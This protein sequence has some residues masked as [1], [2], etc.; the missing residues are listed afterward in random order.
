MDKASTVGSSSKLRELRG[1]LQQLDSRLT[2]LEEAPVVKV[3]LARD[4]TLKSVDYLEEALVTLRQATASRFALGDT[5]AESLKVDHAAL[6]KQL[7]VLRTIARQSRDSTDRDSTA[8]NARV[9]DDVAEH[10]R[11]HYASPDSPAKRRR[12]SSSRERTLTA[13]H[14][15]AWAAS[16][17]LQSEPLPEGKRFACVLQALID[18]PSFD[19]GPTRP[20]NASTTKALKWNDPGIFER[21]GVRQWKH[22]LPL[23]QRYIGVYMELP[24]L[25]ADL[26][27]MGSEILVLLDPQRPWFSE[28]V[29]PPSFEDQVH[30]ICKRAGIPTD[31]WIKRRNSAGATITLPPE[32]VPRQPRRVAPH[33]PLLLPTISPQCAAHLE[34][35]STFYDLVDLLRERRIMQTIV[36]WTALRD[37]VGEERWRS[38]LDDCMGYASS[39]DVSSQLIK[40]QAAAPRQSQSGHCWLVE[41]R[42]C[43]CAA[44]VSLRGAYLGSFH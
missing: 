33:F 6:A 27:L 28:P 44:A 22:F 5:R 32:V 37:R 41:C 3:D 23:A 9:R 8:H 34:Q 1:E 36:V 42:N 43:H 26:K 13:P 21:Y 35:P 11:A 20:T 16:T 7:E 29:Q 2:Q 31:A 40:C 18:A 38:L 39:R 10:S 24:P 17:K 15:P 4:D 12:V 30:E 25:H 19:F 14:V